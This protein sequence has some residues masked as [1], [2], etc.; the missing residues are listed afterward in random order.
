V[1]STKFIF[2]GRAGVTAPG[3]QQN[4]PDA[5]WIRLKGAEGRNPACVASDARRRWLHVMGNVPH[6]NVPAPDC[7]AARPIANNNKNDIF[8]DFARRAGT[9]WSAFA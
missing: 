5:G 8:N 3:P 1:L 9:A 7:A 4:K 2:L 6:R